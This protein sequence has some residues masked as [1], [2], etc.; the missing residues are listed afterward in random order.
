MGE[1]SATAGNEVMV[2]C[3]NFPMSVDVIKDLLENTITPLL[4]QGDGSAPDGH[5]AFQREV[6]QPEECVFLEG[7]GGEH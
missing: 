3:Q 7:C 5:G 4:G 1:G 6:G 2:H